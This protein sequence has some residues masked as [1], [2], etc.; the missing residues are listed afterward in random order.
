MADILDFV[1]T[2]LQFHKLER[3]DIGGSMRCKICKL[4]DVA[5][6]QRHPTSR[7]KIHMEP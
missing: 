2:V 6:F 3:V 4:Q 5:E 7:L 1:K